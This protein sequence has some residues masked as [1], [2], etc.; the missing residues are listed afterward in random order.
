MRKPNIVSIFNRTRSLL[1]ASSF[2]IILIAML[3]GC[4]NKPAIKER[5]AEE[6]LKGYFDKIQKQEFEEVLDM[7]SPL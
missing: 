7:Y 4:E 6:F 2:M 5:E 1:L 3:P